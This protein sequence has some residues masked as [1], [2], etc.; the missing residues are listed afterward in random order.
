MITCDDTGKPTVLVFGATGQVGIEVVQKL[1][2]SCH[3]VGVVRPGRQAPSA[4]EFREA[5]MMRPNELR[6]LV[7]DER[8]SA[9]INAAA[10]TSV[11]RAEMNPDVAMA[12]NGTAPGIIAHE[13][14]RIEAL[15]VHFSTD[16]VF[17]GSDTR[18]WKE[19]DLPAPLNVYGKTKLA[20]E[21]AIRDT[22]VRHVIVRT[23][24]VYSSTGSNFV[25]SMLRL[26]RHQQDIRVVDDQYGAPTSARLLAVLTAKL[27]QCSLPTRQQRQLP[28]VLHASC[29]GATTW[30]DFAETIFIEAT[31]LGLMSTTP[32]VHRIKSADLDRPAR[33]PSNCR[34][35]VARL[36]D[37]QLLPLPHWRDEL[38]VNL[39]SIA[40]QMI[41]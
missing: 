13:A 32:I 23:S 19:D 37:C 40:A 30:C 12:V 25:R 33:R 31:Q 26:A 11:D 3:V 41:A 24:W 9:I 17:D 36:C 7:R 28:N 15:L 14:A 34:L 20:G 21:Q 29:R 27:I 1:R 10:F 35:D 2:R 39:P 4:L 16:Y 6:T 18:P 22:T 5:D 8:P 38:R